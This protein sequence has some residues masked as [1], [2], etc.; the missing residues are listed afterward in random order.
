MGLFLDPSLEEDI[1]QAHVMEVPSD[2]YGLH[3]CYLYK[4][5]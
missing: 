3:G 1:L 2:E 5:I 4:V